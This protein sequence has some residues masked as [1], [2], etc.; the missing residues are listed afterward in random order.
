MEEEPSMSHIQEK[1]LLNVIL[2]MCARVSLVQEMI[3]A[4]GDL[5]NIGAE[6]NDP[7]CGTKM[8]VV[9]FSCMES[10]RQHYVY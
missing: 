6:Q 8:E 2:R 1:T 3:L 9:L 7:F 10:L 4:A 5:G